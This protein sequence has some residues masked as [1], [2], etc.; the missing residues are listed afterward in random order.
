MTNYNAPD[1]ERLPK[2]WYKSK[3]HLLQVVGALT[4]IGTV[5]FG[6]NS[7]PADTLTGIVVVIQ[8]VVHVA[9]V[10]VRQYTSRATTSMV[11][12]ADVGP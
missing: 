8:M 1:F 4:T 10:V 9:T 12:T 6:W 7:L 2:D 11:P 5:F 3:T